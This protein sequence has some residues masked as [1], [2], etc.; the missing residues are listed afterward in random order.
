MDDMP[1]I[2]TQIQSELLGV[3][4]AIR[5]HDELLRKKVPEASLHD[6]EAYAE[7]R[8]EYKFLRSELDAIWG[9]S[10]TVLQLI[11][12]GMGGLVVAAISY[13]EKTYLLMASILSFG[14]YWLIRTHTTRVWRIVGYMRCA[15]E[16]KL[17]GIRWETRLAKRHEALL[18]S[19]KGSLDREIFDGHAIV[20][21]ALN[22][23]I[24]IAVFA[25]PANLPGTQPASV[26]HWV[27]FAVCVLTPILIIAWSRLTERKFK[28]GE[29]LETDH[30]ESWKYRRVA[31]F[32]PA[33][34]LDDIA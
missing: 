1:R 6:A 26:L 24:A 22:C 11:L 31:E 12:A 17:K 16:P 5:E 9:Q 33:S 32:E 28:R 23:A 25:V 21:D 27:Y 20:L 13:H 14:G 15:L 2:I 18:E 4:R 7:Y 10:Y 8:E 29:Q 19:G 3:Q 34:R 30:L